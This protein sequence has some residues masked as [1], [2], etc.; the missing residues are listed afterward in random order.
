VT[1][2]DK[3]SP[4]PLSVWGCQQ[5]RDLGI[6]IRALLGLGVLGVWGEGIDKFFVEAKL[7]IHK[8]R[9]S[10][11]GCCVDV[12]RRRRSGKF[13]SVDRA[14]V[15]AGTTLRRR[16]GATH[17]GGRFFGAAAV[18]PAG[19]FPVVVAGCRTYCVVN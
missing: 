19:L 9:F 7:S 11:V 4:T 18:P 13:E 12:E 6:G 10:M 3:K 15:E 16:L 1:G 5:P 14:V 17:R 8:L 2:W